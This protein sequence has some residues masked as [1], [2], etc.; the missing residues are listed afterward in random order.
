MEARQAAKSQGARKPTNERFEEEPMVTRR[1]GKYWHARLADNRGL[2]VD[3]EAFDGVTVGTD[4]RQRV[5]LYIGGL[6]KAH[7]RDFVMPAD[8]FLLRELAEALRRTAEDIQANWQKRC[9][10]PA[11]FSPPPVDPEDLYKMG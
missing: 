5:Y 6:D 3:G 4:N 8:P 11:P 7:G 10:P 2:T 1:A 9:P